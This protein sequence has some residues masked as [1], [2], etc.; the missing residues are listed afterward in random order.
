MENIKYYTENL[1]SENGEW[2]KKRKAKGRDVTD[3]SVYKHAMTVRNY[4]IP[5]WGEIHPDQ[6]TPKLI[7]KGLLS[8]DLAGATRNG[9]LGCLST[10]CQYLIE[11]DIIKDNPAQKVYRFSNQP[12]KK[13]GVLSPDE[14]KKLSPLEYKELLRI[15]RTQMYVVAFLILRDTGLRPNELRALQWQD[16]DLERKFFPITKAI[17]AGKRFKIKGTKTGSIK[18]A[19]VSEFT[20]QEIERL[21]NSITPRPEDFIFIQKS[22]IPVSSSVFAKN[23]RAGVKRAGIDRSEI[24]PYWLRHTFNTRALERLPDETVRKLMGHASPAM[25]R[26]YR[27]PDIFSLRHEAE[28]IAKKMPENLVYCAT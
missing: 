27:H 19:I 12:I 16:W 20:A 13:R 7:D 23:F 9:I 17:E 5:L 1:F 11:E 24:T 4:I 18:P 2:R 15:W 6:L 25:T 28:E 8:V 14:I 22:G 3:I 10:I 26:H 21:K